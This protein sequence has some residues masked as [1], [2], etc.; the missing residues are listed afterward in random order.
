MHRFREVPCVCTVESSFGES[1]RTDWNAPRENR[2]TCRAT[3]SSAFSC[4]P[5]AL[6]G[7]VGFVAIMIHDLLREGVREY[8]R[9]RA[10]KNDLFILHRSRVERKGC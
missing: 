7:S 8:E 2:F 1:K 5:T 4:L 6:L 9:E 10:K 3:P